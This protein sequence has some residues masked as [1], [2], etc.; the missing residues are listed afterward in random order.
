VTSTA[1]DDTEPV[2]DII[3]AHLPAQ[4]RGNT[5]VI[6]IRW[7][8]PNH[9]DGATPPLDANLQLRPAPDGGC[10]LALYGSYRSPQTASHPGTDR[11]KLD[12]NANTTCVALLNY[13]A[14][15][16][17]RSANTH[18]M[19]DVPSRQAGNSARD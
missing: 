19:T 11:R 12:A 2:P 5:V 3:A 10:I 14:T 7:A 17:T 9:E 6:A 8:M 1:D 18:G 16:L 4:R 13:I 15:I